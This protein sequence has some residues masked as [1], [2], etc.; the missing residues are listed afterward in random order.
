M[1]N[2]VNFFRNLM[3][4]F[5]TRQDLTWTDNNGFS[6]TK[7][8]IDSQIYGISIIEDS[9]NDITFYEVSFHNINSGAI[10]H[11]AT[12]FNKN[13]F[14]ILGIVSNAI[15]EKIPH[16]EVIYFASKRN[17]SNSTQEFENRKRLYHR[18]CHKMSRENNMIPIV[19]D[20][21]DEVVYGLCKTQD[22]ADKF[23]QNI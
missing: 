3:E 9:I 20:L 2:E 4:T 21:D 22:L 19:V 13:Q 18:L 14:K 16:A 15:K 11:S 10:S 12:A 8:I 6:Q 17:S 7:F 1:A 23:K 5:K